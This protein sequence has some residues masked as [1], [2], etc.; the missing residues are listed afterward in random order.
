VNGAPED[1][2]GSPSDDPY[3]AVAPVY[4]RLSRKFS[5]P[6][7]ER[8][9]ARASVS[10]GDHVLDVGTGTGIVAWTA[11]ARV[12]RLGRVVG[13]DLSEAML[14][15]ARQAR[16]D[17]PSAAPMAFACMPAEALEV[18]DREFDVVVSLFAVSHLRDP[19][20]ALREM[21]RV[22]RPGGRLVLGLGSGAPLLSAAGLGRRV[23]RVLSLVDTRGRSLVAPGFLE[24][25]LRETARPL[26][27][28]PHVG[29]RPLV[30]LVQAAGFERIVSAW[31]GDQSEIESVDEFWDLQA[32]FSTPAR[33]WLAAAPAD[34]VAAVR[35][36][37]DRECAR[38]RA[39]GGRLL[40]PQGA[41]MVSARRPLENA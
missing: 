36:R 12:G 13:V 35:D 5:A 2:S 14:A 18:P 22:V 17:P 34:A 21:H 16:P 33:S 3:A 15:E 28:T 40:Y 4:A 23:G 8:L 31:S 11:A 7:A 37:F 19:A 9:V 38:T 39:R 32:T 25:L 6:L 41:L 24:G 29:L 1:G 27:E 10:A 20:S 30:G 26:P